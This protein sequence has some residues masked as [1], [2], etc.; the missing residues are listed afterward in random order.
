MKVIHKETA[1][2]I[3][4]GFSIELPTDAVVVSAAF[5]RQKFVFWY[6]YAVGVGYA[7]ALH[8]KS[9]REFIVVATGQNFPDAYTH[10]ATALLDQDGT[11]VYHLLEYTN[12]APVQ[13][14]QGVRRVRVR[15]NVKPG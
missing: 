3:G 6:S 11:E 5:Q 8:G 4:R 2:E 12:S 15:S 1:Q 14:T 13:T 7:E 9:L 10:R